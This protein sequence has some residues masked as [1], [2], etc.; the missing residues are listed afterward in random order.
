MRNEKNLSMKNRVISYL[1]QAIYDCKRGFWFCWKRFLILFIIIIFFDFYI[2]KRVIDYEHINRIKLSIGF[3]DYLF[4]IFQGMPANIVQNKMSFFE[5]PAMWL[6]FHLFLTFCMSGYIQQEEQNFGQQV[7]L[8]TKSRG[9]W[10]S[11]KCCW[12]I[13]GTAVYYCITYFVTALFALFRQGFQPGL[14]AQ[15]HE[16]L[17]HIDVSGIGNKNIFVI[18]VLMPVILS[19]GL[20]LFQLLI[21][22]IFNPLVSMVVQTVILSVSGYFCTPFLPG[23][24]LMLMR[25]SPVSGENIKW[26]YGISYG[27]LLIAACLLTGK[28]YYSRKDL[29][30]LNYKQNLPRRGK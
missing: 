30:G 19:T 18:L 17:S 20:M 6:L 12:C 11:G 14:S 28:I 1:R 13:L 5:L 4:Q 9:I 7:L 22:S 8:R 15:L 21:S 24:Y 16:L 3:W 27:I 29:C 10:W 25:L 26:E 2:T 23:N